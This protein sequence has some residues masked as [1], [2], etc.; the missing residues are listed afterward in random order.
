[1]AHLKKSEKEDIKRLISVLYRK[2]GRTWSGHVNHCVAEDVAIMINERLNPLLVDYTV[3]WQAFSSLVI[4]FN[5][6]G[7]NCR[8]IR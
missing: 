6:K 2:A 8:G 1:M 7:F 5:N 3:T 4:R